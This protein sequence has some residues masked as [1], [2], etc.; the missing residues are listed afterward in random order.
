MTC[1]GTDEAQA[2][3]FDKTTL[4]LSSTV[5]DTLSEGLPGKH[6]LDSNVGPVAVVIERNAEGSPVPVISQMAETAVVR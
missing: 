2:K 5:A 4:N 1:S 6:G 3:R